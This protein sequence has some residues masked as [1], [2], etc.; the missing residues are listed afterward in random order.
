MLPVTGSIVFNNVF[1][2]RRFQEDDGRMRYRCREKK[3]T[4][5]HID[6]KINDSNYSRFNIFFTGFE[7]EGLFSVD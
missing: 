6:K 7:S 1:Q 4:S 3:D 2:K 5:N